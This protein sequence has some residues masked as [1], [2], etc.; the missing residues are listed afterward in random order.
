MTA[1]PAEVDEAAE[2]GTSIV[3]QPAEDS[4]PRSREDRS[5]DRPPPI[6]QT[7][8]NAVL[9]TIREVFAVGGPR[10]REDAI[11]EVAAALGYQRTGHRIREIL[12]RE[13]Q[14]AVRRGILDNTSGQLSLLCRSIEQYTADHL[15]EML[16]AAMGGTWRTRD[17]AITAAARHLGFRRTG[18]KIRTAFKS[19][20][21]AAIRRG[22]L[23]RD[24]PD[25]IRR[26]R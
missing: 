13:I 23:E 12:S 14:T 5:D 15:V 11:R 6:D 9:A 21:N 8:R 2:P 17:E 16:L 22:L 25:S 7:D 18:E 20:I 3:E 19:A 4:P 10:G 26:A 24:G 1:S